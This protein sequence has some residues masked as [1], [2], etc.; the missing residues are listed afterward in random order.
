MLNTTPLLPAW[1]V[2][3][4]ALILLL[5]V[6]TH[7]LMLLRSNMPARRRRLRTLSGWIML[8]VVPIGAAAFGVVTPSEPRA[9]VFIWSLVAILMLL[10]IVVSLLDLAHAHR[11]HQAERRRLREELD[12][13]MTDT[14]PSDS[15]SHRTHPA[16]RRDA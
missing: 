1:I 12:R 9:F 3:P 7:L 6:A 2:L 8:L 11:E 14:T 16:E 13:P 10:L 4:V 15:D 5:A